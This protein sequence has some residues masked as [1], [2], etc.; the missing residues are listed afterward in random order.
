VFLKQ[1]DG[2]FGPAWDVSANATSAIVPPIVYGTVPAGTT[3]AFPGFA[4]DSLTPG[5]TYTARVV[6]ATGAVLGELIFVR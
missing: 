6:S 5:E 4:P 3:A 1:P 2:I